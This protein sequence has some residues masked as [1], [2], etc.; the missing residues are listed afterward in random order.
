MGG[1]E[2]QKQWAKFVSTHGA[3]QANAW[4]QG[5]RSWETPRGHAVFWGEGRGRGE[6]PVTLPVP[7]SHWFQ[8]FTQ[9]LSSIKHNK[10]IIF[11]SGVCLLFA[12]PALHIAVIPIIAGEFPFSAGAARRL[13]TVPNA[14]FFSCR[15]CDSLLKF[16]RLGVPLC[17]L[18][19]NT[20]A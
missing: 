19:T 7:F 11:Y 13:L 17:C 12:L 8:V 4:M 1:R 2:K 3:L 9:L 10:S 15:L 5:A 18:K 20:L 16:F 6:L 14:A